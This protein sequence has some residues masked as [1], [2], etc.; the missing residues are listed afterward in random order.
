MIASKPGDIVLVR[1]PFTDLSAA[2]QRP[3]LVISPDAYA[4]RHGDVVV[5]ALT[6]RPQPD[7]ATAIDCWR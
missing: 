4:V 7:D 5:L 1:F 6:S 2:K 3:A